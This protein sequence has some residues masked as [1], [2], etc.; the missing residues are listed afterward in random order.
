MLNGQ[1]TDLIHTYYYYY[2]Y[3][4][5]LKMKPLKVCLHT[6]GG[7]VDLGVASR[8]PFE[9]RRRK[10][11]Q[12]FTRHVQ[13]LPHV[14]GSVTCYVVPGYMSASTQSVSFQAAAPLWTATA[15]LQPPH[16][17]NT[18]RASSW[19]EPTGREEPHV[20][21]QSPYMKISFKEGRIQPS[22]V[23]LKHNRI[24]FMLSIM[25]VINY[26]LVI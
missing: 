14:Q 21:T 16:W 2:F 18:P 26:C 9:R 25:C 8:K 4:F 5:F 19:T 23:V 3:Y 13:H 10:K 20:T 24:S 11:N 22:S 7:T 6:R 1:L 15:G 12:T 17:P